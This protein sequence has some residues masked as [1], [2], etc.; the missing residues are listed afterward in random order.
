M[1]ILMFLNFAQC[2]RCVSRRTWWKKKKKKE[3]KKPRKPKRLQE[4]RSRKSFQRRTRGAWDRKGR[5]VQS[6]TGEAYR[7]TQWRTMLAPSP[8][9]KYYTTIVSSLFVSLL[10]DFFFSVF[11]RGVF[12]VVLAAVPLHI[13]GKLNSGHD[14]RLR[15]SSRDVTRAFRTFLQPAGGLR[16]F[17]ASSFG[18]RLSFLSHT[19]VRW[20]ARHGFDLAFSLS[21]SLSIVCSSSLSF[22]SFS[23]RRLLHTSA[24]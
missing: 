12:D 10:N 15:P 16:A 11:R 14:K 21:F 24:P 18:Y 3:G 1:I 5:V 20:N 9:T 2:A 22:F 4:I 13:D 19:P 17:L 6:K 8:D 7:Y 23:Q